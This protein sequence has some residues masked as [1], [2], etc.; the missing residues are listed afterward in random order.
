VATP[1]RF[2][3]VPA[4]DSAVAPAANLVTMALKKRPSFDAGSIL[5]RKRIWKGGDRFRFR[6]SSLTQK[7]RVHGRIINA[8]LACDLSGR[9]PV[10]ALAA[11]SEITGL[12]RDH[13]EVYEISKAEFED[14]HR[15]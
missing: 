4:S 5:S 12:P 15:R 11:A 2:L 6:W 8:D 10:A 13:F 9:R 7:P 3:P 14:L 1:L